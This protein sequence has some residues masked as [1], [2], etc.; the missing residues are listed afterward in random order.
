[1]FEIELKPEICN[2]KSIPTQN[3]CESATLL[4]LCP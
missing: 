3:N 4:D 1:M 2:R